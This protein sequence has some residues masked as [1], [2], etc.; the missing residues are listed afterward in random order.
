[1][2]SQKKKKT[3]VFTTLLFICAL[4]LSGQTNLSQSRIWSELPFVI[5]IPDGRVMVVWTEGSFN[6]EGVLMY[7]IYDDSSGW[8]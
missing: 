7:R 3:I 8:T 2:K 4:I 6:D 1:M 5:A